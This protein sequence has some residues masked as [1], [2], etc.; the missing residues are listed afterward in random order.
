MEQRKRKKTDCTIYRNEQKKENKRESAHTHSRMYLNSLTPSV[1]THAGEVWAPRTWS[2][3]FVVCMCVPRWMI[4]CVC[5]SFIYFYFLERWKRGRDCWLLLLRRKKKRKRGS[6]HTHA[7]RVFLTP[8]SFFSPHFYI[9][10]ILP[11]FSFPPRQLLISSTDC[12]SCP[13]LA[14]K[15]KKKKKST[16]THKKKYGRNLNETDTNEN[17]LRKKGGQ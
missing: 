3:Q 17:Y 14:S 11:F 9:Q 7:Q 2:G 16:T 8:P 12:H 1:R 15:K 4:A 13:S 6:T 10:F 5:V